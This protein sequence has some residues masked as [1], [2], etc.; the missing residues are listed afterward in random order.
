M[1]FKHWKT[2]SCLNAANNYFS[3][4]IKCVMFFY[5]Q[6]QFFFRNSIFKNDNTQSNSKVSKVTF[7]RCKWSCAASQ[8]GSSQ[9][10]FLPTGILCTVKA[11]MLIHCW[12]TLGSSCSKINKVMK[13]CL[14]F[15]TA[16]T[17]LVNTQ[18]EYVSVLQR[19]FLWCQMIIRMISSP[20]HIL[21][22]MSLQN[23]ISSMLSGEWL[24]HTVHVRIY[25]SDLNDLISDILQ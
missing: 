11:A 9:C 23:R 4:K 7:P 10:H 2:W 20:G 8:T 12:S 19:D 14:L 3:A 22:H 21:C 1:H 15:I 24:K 17:S 13:A 25:Y 16:I 6:Q 5:I 18:C